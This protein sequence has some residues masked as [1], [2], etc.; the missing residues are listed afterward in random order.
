MSHYWDHLPD[1]ERYA[2][3]KFFLGNVSSNTTL[4]LLI[5][6]SAYSAHEKSRGLIHKRGQG[7]P[8]GLN[9]PPVR[10][11]NEDGDGPDHGV[12]NAEAT[13]MGLQSED[14]FSGEL[15]QHNIASLERNF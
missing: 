10:H 4:P 15:L 7:G 9:H 1:S 11:L 3:F 6:Y 13:A 14:A 5:T 12:T 2:N 8:S